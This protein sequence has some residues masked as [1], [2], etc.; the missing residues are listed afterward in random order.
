LSANPPKPAASGPTLI[1]GRYEVV[2]KLGAGAFGTVY[3]AKDRILGRMLAIKTIRLEGLAAQGASLEELL[4]RFKNEA[5]VSAQLKHPNIVTIYDIGE[6]DG[7]SYLAMEFLEGTGLDRLIVQGGPM[8]VERAASLGA[9]V[10]DALGFAHKHG[11]VHRDIKPANIMVEAGDRVKVTDFGIA[12]SLESTEHLT[13]T[14]SLLGTPSYMSPEQARGASDLD[15]R[16]DLFAVG[17]ILY[18]MITGKKAFRG[19]S[20]TALIFKIITEQPPAI[21]ELATDVPDEMVRII[22]KALEKTPEARYQSGR[23]LADDLLRLTRVGS[24]P[25]LRATETPTVPSQAIGGSPTIASVSPTVRTDEPPTLNATLRSI[26]TAAAPPPLPKSAAATPR[27]PAPPSPPSPSPPSLGPPSAR[28]PRPPAPGAAPKAARRAGGGVGLLIGLAVLGLG[29]VAVL[30]V[31]GWYFFLRKPATTTVASAVERPSPA[32]ETP[33]PPSPE[34]ATVSVEPVT[35]ASTLAPPGGDKQA[36]GGST[37]VTTPVSAPPATAAP[38]PGPGTRG[39]GRR[40]GPEAKPLAPS[41]PPRADVPPAAA[42]GDAAP[43][44]LDQEPEDAKVDGT[45]AGRRLA[46]GYRSEQGSHTSSGPSGRFAPRARSPRNLRP[47]EMPAVA[48]LRHVV[49]AEEAY[50]KKH[51]RYGT[52]AEMAGQTLFVDV[53]VQPEAFQRKGYKFQ[54]EVGKDGFKVVAL[55]MGPGPQPFIADDSGI[56]RAGLE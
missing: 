21:R 35:T 39:S 47:A 3:K 31:A 24:S 48:T 5:Q 1:A 37:S 30:A 29:G 38:G 20:I 28:A 42:V 19:E 33:V 27:P 32:V 17:C 44:F 52:F 40:A 46:E 16:S 15:G 41:V 56:I 23:E 9:Q 14:G 12:K 11:V 6:A 43:S 34:P 10:A 53:P 25:T 45:E 50:S 22:T 18:E 51:G 49:V 8:P 13:M 26:A 36:P 54:L 2:H 7:L 4:K 55:P